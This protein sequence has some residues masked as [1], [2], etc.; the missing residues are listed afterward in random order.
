M[1]ATALPSSLLPLLA[2]ILFAGGASVPPEAGQTASAG[3]WVTLAGEHRDARAAD[4]FLARLAW[5]AGWGT[6]KDQRG[7]A[8]FHVGME[9]GCENFVELFPER[10]QGIV[11]FSLTSL[12]RSFSA[13]LVDYALGPGFSPLAW[14][15]YG[16]RTPTGGD[17]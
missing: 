4:V 12:S 16:D 1:R 8:F 3:G 17:E 6:F 10:R 9:E 5:T 7:R 15:E 13:A 11:F 2:G 14:L